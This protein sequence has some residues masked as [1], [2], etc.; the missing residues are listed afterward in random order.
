MTR[1]SR[2]TLDI[3]KDLVGFDT[4]S[5]RS[6]LDLIDYIV[7]YLAS[8]DIQSEIIYDRHEQ[9]ANLLAFTGSGNRPAIVLS[10]HTD[11][12]PVDGQNWTH[13]PFSLTVKDGKAF[14]RG[15]CDMK[16]FIASALAALPTFLERETEHS[17]CF[18]FSYDEE[19]GCAGVG[20]LLDVL[21]ER[22]VPV[23]ACIIGEPSSMKP[24]TAHTGKQVFRC[25]FHGTPMHSSL[26]PKGVNAIAYAGDIIN[27]IND[28]E[29]AIRQQTTADDRFAFP[30]PTLN[31]GTISGGKAVNIVAE[32]CHFDVEC[33][34]PPGTDHTPFT[35]TLPLL[36]QEKA[37]HPMAAVNPAAGAECKRLVS[38]PAFQADSAADAVELARKL[39][40]SNDDL[41]VNY[42][43]EAGLFQQ[44]GFS[45]VVCGPGN[46]AQAHQPDE[47]IS[48]SELER[49]DLFMQAL[50]KE[51]TREAF[52]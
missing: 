11:V 5:F 46:I 22:G 49:C 34:F 9:K 20:S 7:S 43:T 1:H 51:L 32:E 52:A 39:T 28:L 13:P 29:T 27:R 21:T 2:N 35:E 26:S 42:G 15:T 50:A 18:A 8:Y 24:V 41:A 48:L 47:F 14:G 6:N 4:T 45:S 38:Y 17:I 36:I 40:G 37:N 12:V 19:V 44:A 30:H 10:G 25:R 3:L 33:R 23:R 16:G 31:I